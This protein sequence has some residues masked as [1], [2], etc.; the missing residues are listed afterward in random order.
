[1]HAFGLVCYYVVMDTITI[2]KIEYKKLKS[3]SNAYLKIASK[4]AEAEREFPY[5]HSYVD[6]LVEQSRSD[7]RKGRSI[8][9]SSVDEALIKFR[10]K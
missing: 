6:K 8:E 1:M 2:P 9:A 7:H 5:D 3:Y 10:R 4:L